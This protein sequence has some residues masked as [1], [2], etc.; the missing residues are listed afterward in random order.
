[1]YGKPFYPTG[2]VPP[3]QY[4]LT[5]D[6]LGALGRYG[7]CGVVQILQV[8]MSGEA[9]R[10]RQTSLRHL[11]EKWLG[12]ESEIPARVTRFKRSRTH[13]WR[14]VCVESTRASGEIS[15][16]FFRHDDGSWCVFPP[17]KRRLAMDVARMH[18]LPCAGIG[19]EVQ[20][21]SA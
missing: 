8:W 9:M 12:T 11:V 3:G 13:P 5:V 21:K 17:D 1:M 20:R 18:A 4:R 19:V 10:T 6:T 16:L 14:C 7:V 2:V 15:I